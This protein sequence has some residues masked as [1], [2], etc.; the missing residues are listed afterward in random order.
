MEY[1]KAIVTVGKIRSYN[2][3]TGE[4]VSKDG[5]Y[6]FTQDNI[7]EG[8]NISQNDIVVFRGELVQNV[9]FAYFIKKVTP[10]KLSDSEFYKSNKSIKLLKGN[11]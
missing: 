10:S 4:V 2:G 3:V 5:I 11:D 9:R 8:E 6:I 1:N 7:L